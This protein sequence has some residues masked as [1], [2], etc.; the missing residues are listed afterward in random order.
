MQTGGETNKPTLPAHLGLILDGNRRWAKAKGLPSLEGH[1]RGYEVLKTIG[2]AA[3]ARGIP[4]VTVYGFSTENWHRSATEV[5]FLMDLLHWIATNEIDIFHK[6][7]IRLVFLGREHPI[8]AKTMKV[9]MAA[10]EKTKNNT[11]GTIAIC[12]NYGGQAEIA[13]AARK[14]VEA[15][16][17]PEDVTPELMR[18]NLYHPEIPDVDLVIRTSGEQR[19]SNFMLLRAAYSE[20]YFLAEKHW[21]DFTSEDLDIAL[22]DYARRV[23]R[24]GQ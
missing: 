7:N 16:V 13:D 21:P 14:I 8:P 22:A 4:Y 19:L 1:K 10:E 24:F 23:R 15:G 6:K 9:I 18:D 12:I 3:I 11:A 2:D 20:F 17:N 5:K